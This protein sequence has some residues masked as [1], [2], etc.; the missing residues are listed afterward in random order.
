MGR[1]FIWLFVACGVLDRRC[2]K[3]TST[4]SILAV[5]ALL[6]AGCASE[7]AGDD[8]LETSGSADTFSATVKLKPGRKVVLRPPQPN[9]WHAKVHPC[10]V[11]SETCLGYEKIGELKPAFDLDAAFVALGNAY[12]ERTGPLAAYVPLLQMQLTS[13]ATVQKF[14]LVKQGAA[15]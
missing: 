5:G 9:A 10:T 13:T 14:E 4:S 15:A 7:P 6:L 8:L 3:T 2:M 1:R 12:P 11:E